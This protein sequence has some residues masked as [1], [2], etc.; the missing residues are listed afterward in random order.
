MIGL[1]LLSLTTACASLP[2]PSAS[3]VVFS[4]AGKEMVRINATTGAARFSAPR[5]ATVKALIGYMLRRETQ[6]T[7]ALASC[8]ADAKAKTDKIEAENKA[9]GVEV[10]LYKTAAGPTIET[11]PKESVGEKTIGV[12]T[13]TP[14]Q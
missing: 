1:T 9:L 7:N 13:D 5:T 2:A 10:E 4:D 11:I 8:Q 12:D 6:L 3:D 14:K